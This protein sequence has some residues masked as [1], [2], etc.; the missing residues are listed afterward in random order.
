[1]RW[2]ILL[3]GAVFSLIGLSTVTANAQE[4]VVLR[5]GFAETAPG[6]RP[7]TNSGIV[8]IAH[9]RGFLDEEFKRD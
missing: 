4:E 3:A 1:M 5:M 9:A 6:N 2:S 8:S 7:F